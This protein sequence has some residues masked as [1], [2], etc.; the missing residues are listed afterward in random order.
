MFR[1]S[2]DN[3]AIARGSTA[4]IRHFVSNW[5]RTFSSFFILGVHCSV[6]RSWVQDFPTYGNLKHYDAMYISTALSA[7]CEKTIHSNTV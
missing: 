5:T 4:Q 7:I 1:V 3:D 6:C 2:F